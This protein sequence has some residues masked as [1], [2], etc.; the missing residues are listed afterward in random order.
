MVKIECV[1]CGSIITANDGA[2]SSFCPFCG[3]RNVISAE[4]S[5]PASA[6]AVRPGKLDWSKLS[7]KITVAIPESQP[8]K[9][10]DEKG[11]ASKPYIFI[12]YAHKDS[13]R[14]LPI[15]EALN[16]MGFRVWYDASIEAGTEWPDYIA[17]RLL[18]CGCFIAF[19]SAAS[20]ESRNCRQEIEFAVSENKEILTVYL[21]DITLPA[22]LRMRLG[23]V[24]AMYKS[25]F[26]SDESFI[27][28]L[29]NARILASCKT[30]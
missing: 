28:E 12:S 4:K 10:Y 26:P 18:S 25:R 30:R 1:A 5:K 16:K 17:E 2:T 24:Q 8:P 23:L 14:V 6:T 9:P 15:I 11:A 21:D 22:G 3:M 29:S 13:Y 20:I 7:S 19:L 27:F